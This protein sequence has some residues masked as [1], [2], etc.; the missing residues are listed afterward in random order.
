MINIDNIEN[1]FKPSGDCKWSES[2]NGMISTAFPDATLAGIRILNAGGNAVDA[3]CTAA[4]SLGV[5]E[6]QA[7]GLGGQTM[8]LI[9]N[10]NRV[11]AID[12]SSRA[13]SLAHV[14]SIYKYDKSYGY[15]AT[16]VPS[17]LATLF[18]VHEK[19]GTL[20]WNMIVSPSIETASVGYRIT[21]LQHSLLK[22]EKEN[23][24]KVESRSGMK[25]FFREEIPP[26]P[27]ETFIQKELAST[28]ETISETGVKSFYSGKIAKMIDSDMREHGGL[29]RF[30]DLALIPW[31]IERKPLRRKFRGLPVYSM[32]PPGAGRSLL[33]TLMMINYLSPATFRT[34]EKRR[35]HLL[36]EIFR[37]AI[38]ERNDRPYDPN[39]YAQIADMDILNKKFCHASIKEIINSAG[40]PLPVRESMDELRGETTH[41]SVIDKNGTAVSLTQSIERVYGSKAAVQGAGFL[42][43]NYLLDFDYSLPAHPFYLRPNAN[44][45]A[46]VAPTLIYAGNEVWMAVG[47]PGSE[48]ILSSIAQFL[49]HVIDEHLPISEAMLLP[50]LHCSMGG[51]VSIEA[52]RFPPEVITHLEE[53]GYRI[54]RREDYSFYLGAIH[55]VLKKQTG[56]GFQGGAEISS[57]GIA[58]GLD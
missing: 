49:I 12:G 32:P 20:P 47:S 3:A 36:C 29:L 43:N 26:V 55:A 57:D 5:C 42:Y 18:Y 35:A 19:Y 52:N 2:S 10:K 53:N 44:P 50:R 27:G 40:M 45:W 25:Y 11:I 58:G 38:L 17:T 14:N 54:D 4:L 31:P 46:S 37:K 8:M 33:Y 1:S 23:F 15:R 21:E 34:D 16:T 24:E 51:R 9:G 7:S 56:R 13:P 28:L 6:P 39:F 30:D 22:R 48:R 41:L